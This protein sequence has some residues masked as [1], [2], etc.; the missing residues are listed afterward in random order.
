MEEGTGWY[1][2]KKGSFERGSAP[3]EDFADYIPQ[4]EK[5]QSLYGLYLTLGDLPIIAAIKVY[6]AYEKAQ[7]K[8]HEREAQ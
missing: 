1:N 7:G 4:T 3:P 5:A 2:F 8:A 6:A